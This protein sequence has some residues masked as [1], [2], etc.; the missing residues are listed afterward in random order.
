MGDT[1]S[2]MALPIGHLTRTRL[3]QDIERLLEMARQRQTEGFVVGVPYT[4]PDPA[5]PRRIG[6]QT[7]QALGFIRELKKRTT[8]PVYEVDESFTSAQAETLLQEAGRQPSRQRAEVDAAAAAL[9][10]QRF[11]DQD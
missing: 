3:A 9:I 6:P 7:R 1:I 10:L 2:R 4:D 8:L 11:L 5:S